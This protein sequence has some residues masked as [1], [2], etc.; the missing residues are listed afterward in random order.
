[1]SKNFKIFLVAALFVLILGNSW[2]FKDKLFGF[3]NRSLELEKPVKE[4]IN[5][6]GEIT[7]EVITPPPLRS[8]KSSPR[9]FLTNAGV[10]KLTNQAREQEKLKPLKENAK[11]AAA[12]K[13]KLDNMFKQQYFAHNSPSGEGPSHWVEQAGY[14]YIVIGENL[15]LGNFEDDAELVLAW[16]NSP[17]HR[18]NIISKRYEEIGVA[19]GKGLFEGESTW[20]AVQEFGLPASACPRPETALRI[21]VDAGEKQI[22][23]MDNR[24]TTLKT[25]L[26]NLK[27]EGEIEAYNEKVNDYNKLVA[28]YNKMIAEVKALVEKYNL[29]VKIYNQCAAG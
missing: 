29:R 12:A 21:Q 16:L 3:F 27:A 18:A 24:L 5:K 23:E 10:I 2:L 1:M 20:L 9:S 25:E 28:A 26:N 15:A 11:L 17:G 19:V 22:N 8:A 4:F 13:A 14:S 6:A 7:R